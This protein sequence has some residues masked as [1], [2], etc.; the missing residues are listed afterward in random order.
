MEYAIMFV[1]HLLKTAHYFMV[2][3]IPTVPVEQIPEAIE[4]MFWLSVKM[5]E[6]Y[7]STLV[8]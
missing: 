3:G 8:F 7:A 5:A 4:A 6:K 2:E 1:T